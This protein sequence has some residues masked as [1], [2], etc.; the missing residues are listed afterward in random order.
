MNAKKDPSIGNVELK[1]NSHSLFLY[2]VTTI[3]IPS[4]QKSPKKQSVWVYFWQHGTVFW[5]PN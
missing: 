4:G 5:V 1:V 2:S 3:I